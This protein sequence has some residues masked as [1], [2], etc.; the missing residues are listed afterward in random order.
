[1]RSEKAQLALTDIRDDILRARRFVEGMTRAEFL[2]DD[3]T[4]YAVTRCLEIVSE[5]SRRLPDGFRQKHA[6]LPWK[7]IMGVGNVYRHNYQ[8]VEQ[9][10]VWSTVH[11]HLDPLLAIVVAALAEF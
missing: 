7:Q 11:G 5:A 1:M 10:I 4:F 3:K 9:N 8:N 6:L 2:D